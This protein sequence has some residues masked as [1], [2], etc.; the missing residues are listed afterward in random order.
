MLKIEFIKKFGRILVLGEADVEKECKRIAPRMQQEQSFA[1]SPSS[2]GACE[3]W[4]VSGAWVPGLFRVWLREEGARLMGV[5]EQ[6]RELVRASKTIH[7]DAPL[8]FSLD[9]TSANLALPRLTDADPSDSSKI[10]RGEAAL[11]GAWWRLLWAASCEEVRLRYGDNPRIAFE[12]DARDVKVDWTLMELY[13]R[14][15][16]IRSSSGFDPSVERELLALLDS[17]LDWAK[18]LGRT[19]ECGRLNVDTSSPS[20]KTSKFDSKTVTNFWHHVELTLASPQKWRALRYGGGTLAPAAPE[21]ETEVLSS[22]PCEA[23]ETLEGA[24]CA[25]RRK[26]EEP[27]LPCLACASGPFSA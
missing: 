23:V 20:I 18:S 8:E 12:S 14:L 13:E 9:H 24:Q 22:I 26:Q 17:L 10:R 27:R 19:F 5:E 11:Y 21:P 6:W 16:T 1:L 25:K 15:H 4:Y 3:S 2:K 7:V